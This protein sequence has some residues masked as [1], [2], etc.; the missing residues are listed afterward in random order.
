MEEWIA[1]RLRTESITE[2]SQEEAANHQKQF[3]RPFGAVALNEW[4]DE[5]V[6]FDWSHLHQSLASKAPVPPEAS[7]AVAFD[8]FYH[9]AA[10]EVHHF[11]SDTTVVTVLEVCIPWELQPLDGTASSCSTFSASLNNN[12]AKLYAFKR[13]PAGLIPVMADTNRVLS[14]VERQL[15]E[16]AVHALRF[17]SSFIIFEADVTRI[18]HL[19]AALHKTLS[20]AGYLFN[21]HR[22]CL[23]PQLVSG[24]ASGAFRW[25][26]LRLETITTNADVALFATDLFFQWL[27]DSHDWGCFPPVKDLPG[28][29]AK[30]AVFWKFFASSIVAALKDRRLFCPA[31]TEYL[32]DDSDGF[33]ER[34]DEHLTAKR[35]LKG[36]QKW[37]TLDLRVVLGVLGAYDSNPLQL[38][39]S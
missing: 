8:H 37:T 5:G 35:V 38:L 34:V 1:A 3:G 10:Q 28:A 27:Q 30:R 14:S 9:A 7:T 33:L 29:P 21:I 6:I 20:S 16:Q 39:V 11:G 25:S 12:E 2:L 24:S 17:L 13:G 15:R 22:S 31:L 19:T 18:M 4:Y 23:A 32:E 36:P 26:A